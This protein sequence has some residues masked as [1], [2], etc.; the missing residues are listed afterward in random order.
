M[1]KIIISLTIFAVLNCLAIV[2]FA[3][4]EKEATRELTGVRAEIMSQLDGTGKKLIALAEAIPEEKYSWRPGKGVRSI[5]EVFVHIAGA[6]YGIPTFIGM[7]YD[8]S[9]G[10]E[11]FGKLRLKGKMTGKAKIVEYLKNSIENA[12]KAIRD[13]KDADLDKKLKLFG[14]DNTYRGTLM[15]I[16][17]HC[18]EHLGQSIA[19]ARVNKIAPPWSVRPDTN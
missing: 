6:N 10:R 1:R 13:T 3:D 8:G 11:A 18:N 4:E 12:K 14:S 7:K 5:G 19:Y 16:A 2:S 17:T 9:V 15:L